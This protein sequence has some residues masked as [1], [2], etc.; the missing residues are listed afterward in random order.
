MKKEIK[1]S[2]MML[3]LQ[4]LIILKEQQDKSDTK[5]CS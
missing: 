4:T 5:K 2:Q 3:K 1:M